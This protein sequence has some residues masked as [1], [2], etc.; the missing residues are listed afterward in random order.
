V[1]DIDYDNEIELALTYGLIND[2]AAE[3]LANIAKQG[4]TESLW[5][6]TLENYR[7]ATSAGVGSDKDFTIFFYIDLFADDLLKKFFGV[8]LSQLEKDDFKRYLFEHRDE[9]NLTSIESFKNAVNEWIGKNESVHKLAHR[10]TES[11]IPLAPSYDLNK[12][13]TLFVQIQNSIRTGLDQSIALDRVSSVLSVPEKYKFLIWANYHLKN[14]NNKYDVNGQIR[15]KEQ[16]LRREVPMKNKIA[17]D[18]QY[19]YIPKLLGRQEPQ[20]ESLPALPAFDYEHEEQYAIDFETA[21]NKLM[22]RVFAIDKL[23]EKYRRVIKQEQMDAVEDALS[24][25]RRRI[26]K[27]RLASSVKDSIIKTANILEKLQFGDGAAEL[28]AIA[29]DEPVLPNIGNTKMVDREFKT[30][31]AEQRE[32]A[33][34]DAIKR[35]TDISAILKN[36]DLVR[37]L[38]EIDL[39]L[40]KLRMASF[41][42]EIQEAQ[43]KLIDAFGYASNKVEDL[44]PKLRGGLHT[45]PEVIS[46]QI[47]E[48]PPALPA[49]KQLGDEVRE[50]SAG[51]GSQRAQKPEPK[52]QPE[53]EPVKEQDDEGFED[54]PINLKSIPALE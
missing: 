25:L 18:G 34:D 16:Q 54:E 5:Q 28:F 30:V 29:A 20:H 36:R 27:L 46:E 6:S 13:A 1:A 47:P 21:R 35:L 11:R 7:E 15:A 23:L 40:H 42:P 41:F 32:V 44:L 8:S 38:A 53:P 10:N 3:K 51:L 24:E 22:S 43:S 17:S 52:K 50:M 45:Q 14:D 31:P 37:S 9:L 4:M 12:W 26:R 2:Y 39:M 48:A 49:S 33:L 19:Y